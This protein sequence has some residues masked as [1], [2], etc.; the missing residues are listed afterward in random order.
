MKNV[1][2]TKQD[3]IPNNTILFLY[4]ADELKIPNKDIIYQGKLKT[5][6]IKT[7]YIYD[8]NNM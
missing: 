1:D 7:E 6:T 5:A 4:G 3:K 8:K 2:E